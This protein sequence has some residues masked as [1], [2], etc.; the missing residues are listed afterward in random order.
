ML[1]K[2]LSNLRIALVLFVSLLTIPA[3]QAGE[4]RVIIGFHHPPGAAEHDLIQDQHRGKFKRNLKRIKAVSA[5]LSEQ[6]IAELQSKPGV[7]YV[8]EDVRVSIIEP[9][10]GSL[11]Y[12]N[13]WG[14]AHIGSEVVHGMNTTGVGVKVAVLDTG[15]D[16]THP[17][18]AGNIRGGVSFLNG[19]PD[20]NSQDY[21]DDSWNSHGT[22]VAGIIAAAANG[23]E[24]VGVAPS[25][26]IYAVKV[27]DSGGAGYLS[28][29]IAGIEWA[30]ENEMDIVNFSIGLRQDHQ[31][32]ADACAKAFEAG[33]LLIAAAGNTGN[34]AFGE[35]LYPAR[36]AS[37]MAIGATNQDNSLNYMSAYGPDVDLVA[38]GDSIYSTTVGGYNILTGT[39]Q[40]APHVAGVAALILSAGL[41]DL[42]GD[43]AVDNRDLRLRLQTAALDLGDVGR[44]DTYGYG[45]VNA[46]AALLR[47]SGGS[48]TDDDDDDSGSDSDDHGD[49]HADRGQG[50]HEYFPGHKERKGQAA[51]RRL[52]GEWSDARAKRGQGMKPD[53]MR[54]S[55]RISA[56]ANY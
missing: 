39:S 54:R 14:V 13:S 37:V 51:V 2:I 44:D 38:P 23:I 30:I 56:R 47:S 9:V 53:F 12:L 15:V 7:A 25:A 21:F 22:H 34:Y 5:D 32:L 20:S 1:H 31:A 35:V 41:D 49:E 26:S 36:Y 18:L 8:E 11:E 42:D 45:L 6:A 19:D 33:T 27:L 46:K 40:A 43:G 50:K 3:A 48:T 24:T 4:R 28:D 16:D 17:E 10:S 29:L 52:Q 55:L